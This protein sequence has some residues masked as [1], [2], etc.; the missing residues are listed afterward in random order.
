MKAADPDSFL[1]HIESLLS[2]HEGSN[3]VDSLPAYDGPLDDRQAAALKRFD[4]LIAKRKDD[5]KVNQTKSQAEENQIWKDPNRRADTGSVRFS[6]GYFSRI[7]TDNY[8]R[9]L[10]PV[11]LGK[12]GPCL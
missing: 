4:S 8:C 3:N 5:T 10:L 12:L 1:L 11:H 9:S 6:V 7:L 2:Y